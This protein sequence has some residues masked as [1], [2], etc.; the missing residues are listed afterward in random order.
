[1]NGGHG[2]GS[3]SD[4]VISFRLKR[5]EEFARQWQINAKRLQSL[6]NNPQ[7]PDSVRNDALA[8]ARTAAEIVGQRASELAA[9]AKLRGFAA[10]ESDPKVGAAG[11]RDPGGGECADLCGGGA[12]QE[13]THR[14]CAR[15]RTPWLRALH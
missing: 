4:T 12:E 10:W 8:E 1:M 13:L 5:A 3:T 7:T 14:R 11:R 6:A 9:L 15:S 2:R